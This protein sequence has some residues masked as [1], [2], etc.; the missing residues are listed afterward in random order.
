MSNV[1]SNHRNY[2]TLIRYCKPSPVEGAEEEEGGAESITQTV[3]ERELMLVQLWWMVMT[4]TVGACT[5][6]DGRVL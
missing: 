1:N 4:W 3:A 6:L 5:D 2:V